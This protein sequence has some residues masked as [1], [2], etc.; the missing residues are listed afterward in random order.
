MSS[1]VYGLGSFLTGL[2]SGINYSKD[3]RDARERADREERYLSI[4]PK[5]TET[6]APTAVPVDTSRATRRGG[7]PAATGSLSDSTR[8]AY[9]WLVTKGYSPAAAS[10]I[11]GNLIQESGYGL[12]AEAIHDN[13]T[14]IGIAGWRDPSPG[15]GR[16]TALMTFAR[17]RGLDPMNRTTQYAFLD[18]ELNTSEAGV[19]KALRGAT[20]PEEAASIFIGYERPSGWSA[21]NPSGGH[22]YSNRVGNARRLYS[23]Y[24][25]GA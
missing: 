18:H 5:T 4:V 15:Q 8:E 10:G 14:G 20:T 2:T 7:V 16:K 23:T 3:R 21:D 12:N 13:G 17:E 9:D 22:G 11:V 6:V 1:G 19:G 25:E 24:Y